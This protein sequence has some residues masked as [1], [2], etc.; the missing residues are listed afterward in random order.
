MKKQL[1][2]LCEMQQNV[3]AVSRE[4]WIIKQIQQKNQIGDIVG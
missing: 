4:W 2:N 1:Y 3:D